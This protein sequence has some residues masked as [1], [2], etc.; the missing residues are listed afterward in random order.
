MFFQD[1]SS[2]CSIACYPGVLRTTLNLVSLTVEG[3]NENAGLRA[4]LSR[5]GAFGLGIGFALVLT[6]ALADIGTAVACESRR[7]WA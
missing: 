1:N 7:S 3:A 4:A 2:S 5:R 6:D